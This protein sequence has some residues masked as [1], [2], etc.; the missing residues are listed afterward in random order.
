LAFCAY[1]TNG[2]FFVKMPAEPQ[3]F[4]V[5]LLRQGLGT[6]YGKLLP[7]EEG[8][9]MASDRSSCLNNNQPAKRP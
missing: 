3:E 8:Q 2:Y 6:L 1:L 7:Q 9:F 5:F 4:I